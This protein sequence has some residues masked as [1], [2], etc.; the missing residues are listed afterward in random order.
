M[1]T[2]T[3]STP[4][5]QGHHNFAPCSK[6]ERETIIILSDAAP[7]TAHVWTSQADF[8]RWLL[9][10]HPTTLLE[11]HVD[12]RGRV[13]GLEFDLP[14]TSIR[15]RKGKQPRSPRQQAVLERARA[16]SRRP[17]LPQKPL[18]GEGFSGVGE[19]DG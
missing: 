17:A 13:T 8:A 2:L 6:A 5:A 4:A 12:A 15:W 10:D 1:P 9:R 18:T 11:R 19:G 3:Q 7:D 16:A 14:V